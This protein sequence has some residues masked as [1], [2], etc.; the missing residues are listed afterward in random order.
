METINKKE[1][2]KPCCRGRSCC[3]EVFVEEDRVHIK[4]D[5]DGEVHLTFREFDLI[6]ATVSAMRDEIKK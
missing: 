6:V 5:H 2:W 1:Q 4:D 3:P